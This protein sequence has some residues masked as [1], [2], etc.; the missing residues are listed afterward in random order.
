MQASTKE[1]VGKK[2][3]LKGRFLYLFIKIICSIAMGGHLTHEQIRY[4]VPV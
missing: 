4:S 3:R 2:F 1:E